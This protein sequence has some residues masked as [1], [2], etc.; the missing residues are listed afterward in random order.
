MLSF[1]PLK[2][3][4]PVN[5]EIKAKC[6]DPAAIREILKDLGAE[7]KG[8]DHQTDTYFKTDNGRLKLREGNIE[9]NL[10]FYKRGD[11]AGPKRS[12]VLLYPANRNPNLKN[13]LEEVFGIMVVV[14]KQREI[15]FIDNVK[16]HIDEVNDLGSFVEIEAIGD[17]G[18]ENQLDKQCRH[19]MEV[20]NIKE[21]QL[22]CESY[23]DLLLIKE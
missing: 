9:N 14:D 11:Q 2:C 23:C 10:I 7:Y 19:F 1:V 15:Y 13:I 12:D 18:E 6:F 17:K 4:M 22:L 21:E 20:L 5:I 16:F 3:I 8:T